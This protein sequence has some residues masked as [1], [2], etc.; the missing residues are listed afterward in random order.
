MILFDNGQRTIGIRGYKEG[1]VYAM[2]PHDHTQDFF[3]SRDSVRLAE[4]PE[5]EFTDDCESR[6]PEFMPLTKFKIESFDVHN[7][8]VLEIDVRA[9]RTPDK[10]NVQ[11]LKDVRWSPKLEKIL[12]EL[13]MDSMFDFAQAAKDLAAYL[14]EGEKAKNTTNE[15]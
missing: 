13:I 6:A 7:Y 3:L 11:T 14:N 10:V 12:E 1:E 9:E 15:F 4:S 8:C 2:D 5:A